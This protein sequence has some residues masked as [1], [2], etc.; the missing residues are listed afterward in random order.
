MKKIN[1]LKIS[2]AA[3]IIGSIFFVS[4][5]NEDENSN[6]QSNQ[7][8]NNNNMLLKKLNDFNVDFESN[9][10]HSTY[11][12]KIDWKQ[13]FKIAG[14][15]IAG[16]A[17]GYVGG[18][19][20][21]ANVPENYELGYLYATTIGGAATASNAAGI[22]IAPDINPHDVSYGKLNIKIPN[23]YTAFSNVGID[24]NKAIHKYF[25]NKGDFKEFYQNLD[26]VSI[27]LLNSKNF[28]DNCEFIRNVSIEYAL[29]NFDYKL[30]TQR[31]FNEGL[32]TENMKNVTDLFLSAMFVCNNTSDLEEIIN[33][34]I[35][36]VDKSGLKN[37][38]KKALIV[39]FIVAS[40]SPFYL[41]GN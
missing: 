3:L 10:N 22:T 29:N 25:Y 40:E 9:A 31:L 30:L 4:C 35:Y 33:F 18:V 28:K 36:A 34:Y 8:I 41:A 26:P 37:E 27:S 19:L 21:V 20:T 23:E 11:T 7:I 12:S 32:Y 39:S 17:G 6:N 14:A 16:A 2:L 5:N 13:F 15:D 24:H 38:E 1:F